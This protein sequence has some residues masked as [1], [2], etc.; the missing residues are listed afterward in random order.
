M[1]PVL[2]PDTASAAG[3]LQLVLWRAMSAAERLAHA[4]SLTLAVLWLEREGLRRRNPTFSST[5]LHRAAI[6]RR[7]GSELA[8]RVFAASAVDS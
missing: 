8:A 1:P 6:E 4:R 2:S 7:L 3:D 5:E